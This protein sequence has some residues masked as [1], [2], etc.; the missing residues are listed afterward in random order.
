M[1][2]S[3]EAR[4]RDLQAHHVGKRYAGATLANVNDAGSGNLVIPWLKK[5]K[6]FL[7]YLGAPGVGKTYFCSAL[8]PWIDGKYNTY[9]YWNERDLLSR[10]RLVISQEKGDYLKEIEYLLDDQFVMIDDLGSSGVNDWRKEVI[11]EIVDRRYQSEMP[12]VFTSNL[13]RKEIYDQMGARTH[14][15]LFAKENIVIEMH[16]GQDMRQKEKLPPSI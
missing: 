10:L 14:S 5:A 6:N 12:M 9:R 7:I 15:R 8:I 2:E 16:E 4:I 1:S 3:K 13:T 11:F